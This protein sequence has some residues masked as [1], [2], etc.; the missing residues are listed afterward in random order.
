MDEEKGKSSSRKLLPLSQRR[1]MVNSPVVNQATKNG[2]Q[3]EEKEE[4]EES[5]RR[6]NT[7]T[8]GVFVSTNAGK[9]I[10]AARGCHQTNQA[11]VAGP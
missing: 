3:K 9:H 8:L 10:E 2:G 6:R 7:C 11:I 1:S 5:K 4:E